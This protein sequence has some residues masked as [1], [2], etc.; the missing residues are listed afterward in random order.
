MKKSILIIGLCL[1][2]THSI[3][4]QTAYDLE[5]ENN[6]PAWQ[7]GLV[8]TDLVVPAITL[9]A[10][11]KVYRNQYLSFK[12][13]SPF[14]QSFSENDLYQR[15]NWAF[16]GGIYHKIFSTLNE[17][18]MLTFRHGIRMGIADLGFDATA[19]EPY[20][21]FGNTFYEYRDISLNDQLITMGYEVSLGWQDRFDQLYFEVYFGLSYEVIINEA[22]LLAPEYKGEDFNLDLNGPGYEYNSGV[23]PILGLILGITDSD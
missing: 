19:W 3:S 23:R 21:R 5:A 12:A 9:D 7:V 2:L 14:Y 15:T 4:A 13:S 10:S 18:D 17:F 6:L 1:T 8:V 11:F 16:K 20:D 22:D